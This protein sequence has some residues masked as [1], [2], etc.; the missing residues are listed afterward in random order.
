MLY[1]YVDRCSR[2]VRLPPPS[3]GRNLYVGVIVGSKTVWQNASNKWPSWVV[4]IPRIQ[5]AW[6]SCVK[7]PW[8]SAFRQHN[9]CW[10]LRAAY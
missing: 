9:A 4:W 10:L 6:K 8:P 3:N 7:L 5:L 1:A 2:S